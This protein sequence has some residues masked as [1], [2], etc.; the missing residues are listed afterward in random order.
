VVG[1]DQCPSCG[2]DSI[3]VNTIAAPHHPVQRRRKCL[4]CGQR[5]NTYEERVIS[6]RE[7]RTAMESID[8]TSN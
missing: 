7:L 3:V 8:V 4:E 2:A 1:S 5:W 6:T